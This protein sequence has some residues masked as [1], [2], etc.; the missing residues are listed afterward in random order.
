MNGYFRTQT[1]RRVR[2]RGFLGIVG[3]GSAAL[4][5]L[6]VLS[7]CAKSQQQPAASTV[8]APTVAAPSVAAP[9]AAAPAAAN[10]AGQVVTMY[11]FRGEE[12][13]KG[14]DGK[15][16]DA[17]VPA[18]MVV[19]AGQPVTVNVI[20][21]DEGAHTVTCPQLNLDQTIKPGSQLAGGDIGP[22]TTTFTFT[23]PNKGVFRWSCTLQC[24][25][26]G[27]Y[28]AMSEAFDGPGQPGFMAGYIVVV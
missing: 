13:I 5:S 20:N 23:A 19:K 25:A 14:P 27:G 6:A 3:A 11:V 24:D 10:Q 28:W 16:H 2:R 26:G 22:V 9:G 4:G 7:A 1:E 18:S 17:F 21:S 12:G 8:V 15:G